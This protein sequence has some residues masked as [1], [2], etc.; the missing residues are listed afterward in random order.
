LP[1]GSTG[2]YKLNVIKEGIGRTVPSTSTTNDFS[3][4]IKIT[5]VSP[6]KGSVNGGTILTITG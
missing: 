2:D 3:Y 5:N 1:G 6:I 4:L